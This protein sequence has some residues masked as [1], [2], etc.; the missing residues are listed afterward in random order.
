MSTLYNWSVE[1]LL[2][3]EGSPKVQDLEFIFRKGVPQGSVLGPILYTIY[4]NDIQ[5]A[6]TLRQSL[7]AHDTSIFF[8]TKVLH[9]RSPL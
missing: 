4:V 5:Y 9:Y 7:F 1:M 6:A 8:L 2:G 3:I